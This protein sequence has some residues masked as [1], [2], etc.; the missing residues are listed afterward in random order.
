[1]IWA[2]GNQD[3]DELTERL[4]TLAA[5][6]IKALTLRLR[7]VMVLVESV[8]TWPARLWRTSC[9]LTEATER[10]KAPRAGRTRASP[11]C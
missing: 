1:M 3:L 6:I 4:R 9:L 8:A 2:I 5:R 10:P 11:M 7:D